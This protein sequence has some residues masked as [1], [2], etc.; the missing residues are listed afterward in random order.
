MNWELLAY[1]AIAVFGIGYL[2]EIST[3]ISRR[4]LMDILEEVKDINKTNTEILDVLQQ[5][6]DGD[7][8]L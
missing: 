5:I 8:E 1:L 3:N 4:V 2:F 7:Y 6:R